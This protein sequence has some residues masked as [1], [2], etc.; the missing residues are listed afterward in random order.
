MLYLIPYR[1]SIK[2][3]LFVDKNS[4][5]YVEERRIYRR[6][7][8]LLGY[9]VKETISPALKL[10]LMHVQESSLFRRWNIFQQLFDHVYVQNILLVHGEDRSRDFV[11]GHFQFRQ[12]DRAVLSSPRIDDRHC[13]LVLA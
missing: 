3:L 13:L 4:V 12:Q 5:I 6:R 9:L 10:F 11:V 7:R 2:Y 1:F 8:Y